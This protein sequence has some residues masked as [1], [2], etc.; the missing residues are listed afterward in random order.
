MKLLFRDSIHETI[1]L[2]LDGTFAPLRTTKK[3]LI[4]HS[5]LDP[6][7]SSRRID[8]YRIEAL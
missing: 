5:C 4:P 8:N 7:V 6:R 3:T 1:H 2:T